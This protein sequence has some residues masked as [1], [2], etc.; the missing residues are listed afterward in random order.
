MVLEAR[1]P[2]P[3]ADTDAQSMLARKK[4]GLPAQ[5]P[6]NPSNDLYRDSG[7][8]FSRGPLRT[9]QSA[10]AQRL[11]EDFGCNEEQQLLILIT[12]KL[13]L[14]HEPDVR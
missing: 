5:P 6:I 1:N 9:K 2:D 11:L 13:L 10:Y 7:P 3:K 14:K 12:I 4:K 8:A